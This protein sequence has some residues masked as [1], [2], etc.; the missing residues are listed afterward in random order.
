MTTVAQNSASETLQ[1]F[2]RVKLSLARESKR[3]ARVPE[4]GWCL[5]DELDVNKPGTMRCIELTLELV[6]VAVGPQKEISIDTLEVA[7]DV[8]L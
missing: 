8:F 1:V 6:A 3:R 2:E 7:V 5:V 4:I